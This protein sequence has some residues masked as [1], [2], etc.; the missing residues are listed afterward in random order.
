MAERLPAVWPVV[1]HDLS[2]RWR[3]CVAFALLTGL[4]GVVV[5]AAVAGARRTA[6]AYPRFLQA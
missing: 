1:V 6:S 5:L 4:P 2:A 3:G